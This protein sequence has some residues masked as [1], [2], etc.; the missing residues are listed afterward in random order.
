MFNHNVCGE[1]WVGKQLPNKRVSCANNLVLHLKPT[2]T[3]A[4][5]SQ[6]I[7]FD[8]EMWLCMVAL[9]E[10]LAIL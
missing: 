7:W 4:Q 1:D 2:A 5:L 8:N 3:F 9:L 6:Q 10:N